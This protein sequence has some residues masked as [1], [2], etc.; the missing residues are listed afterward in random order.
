MP[1][2][3]TKTKSTR[4]TKTYTCTG[5]GQKIEPGEVYY[6]W[7]RRFGRSGQTYRRHQKC[8]RP[9]PTELTSRKTA[10]IEEAAN[11]ASAE[12][13]AW[14]YEVEEMG[15]DYEN[16]G[17]IEIDTSALTDALNSVA[18]IAR[19]VGQE[20]QDGFDNMPEGLNQ[21]EVAQMME[22]VAQELDSWADDV[23]SE[24]FD[25]E[26]SYEA[27]EREEDLTDEQYEQAREEWLDN[28]RSTV[29]EKLDELRSQAT[30]RIQDWPEYQG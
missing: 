23:E 12:I 10:Q 19:E 30:E 1:R 22:E 5:C 3:Y 26:V 11:D 28:I 27:F 25:G 21:G 9:R 29:E 6:E 16:G 15:L 20:Y 8:G 17:T 7:S 24:D 18:E 2:V 13:D 14:T 4:G